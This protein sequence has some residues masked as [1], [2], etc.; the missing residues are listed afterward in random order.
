MH[1]VSVMWRFVPILCIGSLVL[2]TV[3]PR[4]AYVCLRVSAP[5]RVSELISTTPFLLSD[6]SPS[7]PSTLTHS[8]SLSRAHIQSKPFVEV[9]YM[10][11]KKVFS[12][13]EVL[14]LVLCEFCRR[15]FYHFIACFSV[16]ACL[17][18]CMCAWVRACARVRM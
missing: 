12:P 1:L 15:V 3:S 7:S 8:L 16:R 5:G 4:V 17:C 9:Q 14:T 2:P 10:G 13:E 6:L 11:G 18:A